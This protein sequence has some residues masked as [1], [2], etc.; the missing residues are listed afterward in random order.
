MRRPL[1]LRVLVLRGL[2]IHEAALC[3]AGSR[4]FFDLIPNIVYRCQRLLLCQREGEGEKSG[5]QK[6]I[7]GLYRLLIAVRMT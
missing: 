4:A 3:L 1:L 5:Q 6:H 2:C 7:Q